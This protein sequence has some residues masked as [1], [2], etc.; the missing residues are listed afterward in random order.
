MSE[1]QNQTIV[2]AKENVNKEAV[3]VK[4]VA[5]VETAEQINWKKFREERAE[6]RKQKE[7]LEKK[8]R[9]KEAEATALKAAMDAILNK[10][11]VSHSNR[12]QE[13]EYE[14]E[15]TEDQRIEKK[16]NALLSAK[17][18]QYEDERKRREQAEFPN[19]LVSTYSDFNQ[20]CTAENLDYLEYHYPE[21]AAAFKHAPDGYD[22]WASVYKAVKRFVP[23]SDNAKDKSKA[24][25][26]FS[27][28]QSMSVAGVTQT[29]D[30]PPMMLDD[31]RRQDNWSR[32]QKV[33]KG[34]K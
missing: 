12:Q 28:P 29:G 30:A 6:E 22:K 32:M 11:P 13:S 23:N 21:V 5:A 34:G 14:E 25:K 16:V 1:E 24:E 20:V 9:E 7:I 8:A 27:K 18:R 31:K 2:E 26:N 19:K 10:Q 17:E 3:A 15:E 4:D 33:M